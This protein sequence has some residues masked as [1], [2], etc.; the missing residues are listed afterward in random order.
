M[1]SKKLLKRS[2]DYVKNVVL[3]GNGKNLDLMVMVELLKEFVY[4]VNLLV[5]DY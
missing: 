1:S 3:L 5:K 2:L 4:I